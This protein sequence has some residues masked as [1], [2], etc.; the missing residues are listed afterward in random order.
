MAT[1]DDLRK[2]MEEARDKHRRAKDAYQ[3]SNSA[4]HRFD[5]GYYLGKAHVYEEMLESNVLNVDE[6][7]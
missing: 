3:T 5:M 4:V 1:N 7:D 2:K 6:D